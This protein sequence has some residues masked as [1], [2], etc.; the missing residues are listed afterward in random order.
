M[1]ELVEQRLRVGRRVGGL[2]HPSLEDLV[3]VRVRVRVRGYMW[4]Q[5]GHLR[6]LHLVRV[7][8]PIT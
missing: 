7:A 4:S 6:R 5:P 2:D 3:R 1:G 8:V